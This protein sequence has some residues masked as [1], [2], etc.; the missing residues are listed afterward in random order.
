LFPE[1]LEQIEDAI[2]AYTDCLLGM[3]EPRGISFE[4]GWWFNRDTLGY[5]KF[6][7]VLATPDGDDQ[8]LLAGVK[9]TS[10]VEKAI[11]EYI[12][13]ELQDK[14]VSSLTEI[15]FDYNIVSCAV[16]DTCNSCSPSA[17]ASSCATTA[18]ENQVYI[19]LY[20]RSDPANFAFCECK[21]DFVLSDLV[22]QGVATAGQGWNTL[23]FNPL[24]VQ[25]TVINAGSNCVNPAGC[26]CRDPN[27]A[28][29]DPSSGLPKMPAEACPATLQDA[30]DAGFVLSTKTSPIGAFCDFPL[31]FAINVGDTECQDSGM[32]VHFDNIG[33]GFPFV[34]GPDVRRYSFAA[35]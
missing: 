33:V 13:P 10:S 20:T 4:E 12:D 31:V 24:L 3:D 29:L 27:A 6:D 19:N 1:S 21:Y 32:I 22:S 26:S 11:L 15:S 7:T 35:E 16:Q 14:P 34:D 18:C 9:G 30:A 17:V 2:E 23:K 8:S 5:H 28:V 25:P